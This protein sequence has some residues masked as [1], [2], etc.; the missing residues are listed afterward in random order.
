MAIYIAHRLRWL[1]CA[2]SPPNTGFWKNTQT[3]KT[4]TQ[5]DTQN[6]PDKITI[7]FYT[8]RLARRTK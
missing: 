4:E 5:A 2:R 1:S 7:D 8:M 6:K 3:M